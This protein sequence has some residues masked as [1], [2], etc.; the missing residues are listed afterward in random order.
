MTTSGR[1]GR[2]T[3]TMFAT[4]A[5]AAV[6]TLLTTPMLLAALGTERFGVLGLASVLASQV[7]LLQLGIGPAATRR[8]AE[9][10]GQGSAMGEAAA[11]RAAL[12]L[13]LLGAI[14][15]GAGAWLL[16]RM[17]WHSLF[18]AS[19]P[20]VAE[21]MRSI[22]TLAAVVAAQP[23]V[24]GGFSVLA[25]QER[26]SVVA[27][28]RAA[29]GIARQPTAVGAVLLADDVPTALLT[30]AV[31]D[32]GVGAIAWALALRGVA[33]ATGLQ[34]GEIV[35]LLTLGLPT[36]VTG[37]LAL[38]LVDVEKLAVTVVRSIEDFVYY[39]TPYNA[40]TRLTLLASA[41][42]GVLMPRLAYMGAAAQQERASHVLKT[43]TN[44]CVAIM[45]LCA[46]PLI[47]ILPDLLTLWL[48]RSFA[49]QAGLPARILLVGLVAQAGV[50]PAHALLRARAQPL[51]ITALYA[52]EV[53]VQLPLA[54]G[55]VKAAGTTGAALAWTSRAFAD[56][57]LQQRMASR[58]LGARLTQLRVLAVPSTAAALAVV[59]SVVHRDALPW[60]I[61]LSLGAVAGAVVFFWLVPYR[62]LVGT[63][64]GAVS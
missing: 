29:H 8:V 38:L 50:F 40:L 14:L 61:R 3:L 12:T 16:G 17:A 7:T 9:W 44:G 26:F 59:F 11:M 4:D 5:I 34:R 27:K 10:R 1:V 24:G 62:M 6:I 32:L 20:V 28:L 45:A 49:E 43:A 23:I 58:I 51:M 25:G 33:D 42:A 60:P 47:F 64:R 2:W 41:L 54:F 19:P 55:M 30:F 18:E 35:G 63:V 48:G 52:A 53:L 13:S 21:A 57:L 36:A 22:P 56:T 15:G 39:G 46:L 31:I 37:M